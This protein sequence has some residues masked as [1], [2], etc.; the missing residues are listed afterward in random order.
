M[1]RCSLL[2]GLPKKPSLSRLLNRW[3]VIYSS[4]RHVSKDS[5]GGPLPAKGHKR[6]GRP[7]SVP[8]ES[9]CSGRR[10]ILQ[11]RRVPS[12]RLPPLPCRSRRS[13]ARRPQNL[14]ACPRL[15]VGRLFCCFLPPGYIF[16]RVLCSWWEGAIG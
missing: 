15:P 8:Q 16:C 13:A 6:G 2:T 1:R 3:S 7:R 12:K 11:R 14:H 5:G 10:K 4:T 9:L